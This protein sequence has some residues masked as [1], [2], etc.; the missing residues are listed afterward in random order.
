MSAPG[1]PGYMSR[2]DAGSAPSGIW[3]SET[4]SMSGEVVEPGFTTSGSPGSWMYLQWA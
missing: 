4:A 2:I 3:I 1:E